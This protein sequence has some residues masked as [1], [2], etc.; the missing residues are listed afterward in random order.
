MTIVPF[1]GEVERGD[2]IISIEAL[3]RAAKTV[4]IP[5]C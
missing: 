1:V 2:K 3:L 4:K 5:N